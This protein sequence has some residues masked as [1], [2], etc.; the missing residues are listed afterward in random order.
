MVYPIFLLLLFLFSY[1]LNLFV[2]GDVHIKKNDQLRLTLLGIR[3]DA[4]PLVLWVSSSACFVPDDP[5]SFGCGT[6][7]SAKAVSEFSGGSGVNWDGPDRMGS[8]LSL[9]FG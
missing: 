2:N 7:T 9:C 6:C 3:G 5:G 1:C 8:L 4:V